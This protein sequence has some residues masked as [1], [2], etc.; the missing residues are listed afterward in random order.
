M[1]RRLVALFVAVASLCAAPA[2]RAAGSDDGRRLVRE[3]GQLAATGK[4]EAAV[5]AY[6]Q[7]YELLNDP[8]I[9]FNRAECLRKLDRGDEALADYKKFLADFPKA[10]N[11]AAVQWRIE[12]L[13]ADK[14]PVTTPVARR[15]PP[16]DAAARALEQRAYPH[17]RPS[18]EPWSAWTWVGI[19][20]TVLAAG[21]AGFYLARRDRTQIPES[22]LGSFSF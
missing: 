15:P 21:A 6:S 20:T 17:K 13:S 12:E 1:T 5:T 22:T 10:P 4:C 19:T 8:A 3:A 18:A 11:R 7:A 14:A 9:L 16:Q 2:T